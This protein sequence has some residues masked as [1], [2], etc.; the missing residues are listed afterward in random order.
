MKIF[1]LLLLLGAVRIIQIDYN[2]DETITEKIEKNGV[3]GTYIS[4]TDNE[5]YQILADEDLEVIVIDYNKLLNPDNFSYNYYCTFFR[6]LFDIVNVKLKEKNERIR[7]LE[8]KTIRDRLL[9]Y[10]EIEYKKTLSKKIYLTTSFKDLAD[11]FGVNRAAMFRELKNL[12]EDGFIE[13]KDGR[14][15]LLY[16]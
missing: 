8:K 13:S 2:G 14:I 6:N 15:T 5:N 1:Y 16:K 9:E 12:K 4:G 7:I 10:F 3:F 11:Y